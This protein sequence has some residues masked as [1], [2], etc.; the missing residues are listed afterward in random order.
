[1]FAPHPVVT[2]ADRQKFY[3][4]QIIRF[5]ESHAVDQGQYLA[6]LWLYRYRPAAKE[7]V[8]VERWAADA[9][10]SSKYARL[11]W[12]ALEGPSDDK[13]SPAGRG[14]QGARSRPPKKPAEP[15][16][17]DVQTAA[18]ALT[19]ATQRLGRELAPAETPAIVAN[20]GNGPIEHLARRRKTAESRDV[21]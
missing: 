8:T 12:A 15:N 21:F 4:Q 18:K 3:E 1:R 7:T 2:F 13:F 5:Y 20:A 11:L 6:S 16:A 17:A 10:L 14:G 19:A 9:G